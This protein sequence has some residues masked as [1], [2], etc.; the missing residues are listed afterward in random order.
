MY[1]TQKTAVKKLLAVAMAIA[2]ALTMTVSAFA[3]EIQPFY[4]SEVNITGR[5]S[6]SSQ[7]YSVTVQAPAGTTQVKMEA[8]LYQ[9]QLIGRKEI[10]SMSASASSARCSQSKSAAIQTGKTYVIEVT[11]EVYSGG[12]WDTIEKTITVKT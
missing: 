9:K 3:A 10:S 11:A 7:T 8:T 12:T 2:M 5:V 6:A 1:T 4:D